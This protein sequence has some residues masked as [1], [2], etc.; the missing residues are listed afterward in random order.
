MITSILVPYF[1]TAV[2]R[3]A[4]P[5]LA[6]QPLI[7]SIPAAGKVGAVSP[8]AAGQGLTP[9]M[10]LNQAQRCCPQVRLIPA[11]PERYDQARGEL[12]EILRT[13]TPKLEPELHSHHLLI[14]LDLDLQTG[15][16]HLAV[17]EEVSRTIHRQ[18]RLLP[19]LGLAAGKFPAYVA[20]TAIG[21]N[22]ALFIAPGQERSF[23]APFPIEQLPLTEALARRFHLLGLKTVG[24]FAR[25]SGGA[26][27][28]QFGSQGRWLHHLARG[29]DTRPLHPAAPEPEETVSQL[30]DD[31][32]ITDRLI[33][34]A[35]GRSLLGMLASR[36]QTNRQVGQ[37]LRVTLTLENGRIWSEEGRLRQ[38]SADPDHWGR[39]LEPVLA[40][41]EIA[42]GITGLTL[43]LAGLDSGPG[44]QLSLLDE[45]P[46][47]AAHAPRWLPAL[48]ARFGPDRFF[49]PEVADPTA[50]LPEQRF[51][52]R[53][54]EEE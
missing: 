41:A 35:V 49:R 48:V 36:L 29:V 3:R 50:F 20:A 23:L 12:L 13:Y 46:P 16:V 45:P 25:L 39:L 14:Y 11:R 31:D 34:A 30:F 47:V 24:Q 18:T 37:R 26:V 54:L 21:L 9:G 53:G 42:C 51:Q 8:E 38:P 17:A 6:G 5:S 10:S 22:R 27:L 7:L 28:T 43:T 19:A 1:E 15:P 2:E 40:R 4:D 33:L 32:P 44:R 52:L